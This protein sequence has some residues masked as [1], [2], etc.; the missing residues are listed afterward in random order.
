EYQLVFHKPDQA[1]ASV[2]SKQCN[3]ISLEGHYQSRGGVYSMN[4]QFKQL[5]AQIIAGASFAPA[6]PDQLTLQQ[7][8]ANGTV[9]QQLMTDANLR[10][11]LY[12]KIFSLPAGTPRPDCPSGAD[13]IA[14]KGRWYT[15]SFTQWDLPLL[16]L[17]AYEG[18]CTQLSLGGNLI[19]QDDREFWDLLHRAARV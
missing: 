14:G 3:T 8:E 2:V 17:Q 12:T 9:S 16:R 6:Q 7:Q 1:I 13:K 5:F 11:Q 15:L 18:S 4:E 19:L 10:Q